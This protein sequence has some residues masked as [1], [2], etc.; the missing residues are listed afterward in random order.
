[1]NPITETY[2]NFIKGYYVSNLGNVKRLLKNGEF[3][4]LKPCITS[5]TGY[6]YIKITEGGK[7]KNIKVHYMVAKCFHGERPP[8]MVIDHIDRNRHNNCKDNLRYLSYSDNAKNTEKKKKS[9]SL[10]KDIDG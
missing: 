9:P 10:P 7:P 3:R 1:M 8:F 5:G 4:D 2:L 6:K